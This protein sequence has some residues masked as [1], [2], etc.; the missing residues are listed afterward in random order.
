[1]S[2]IYD[3]IIIGGGICGLIAAEKICQESDLKVLVLEKNDR[4]GGQIY[5]VVKDEYGIVEHGCCLFKSNKIEVMKLVNRLDLEA[6]KMNKNHYP[7]GSWSLYCYNSTSI[8]SHEPNFNDA[9][10]EVEHIV[11]KMIEMENS[12]DKLDMFGTI[13]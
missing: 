7:N 10:I 8:R 3:V 12:I 1:M 6:C 2:V 13:K 11:Q 5:T 4:I 9:I